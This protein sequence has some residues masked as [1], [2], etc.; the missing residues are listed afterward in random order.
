M[1]KKVC[2]KDGSAYIGNNEHPVESAAK[3]DVESERARAESL[4]RSV[5]DGLESEGV[6]LLTLGA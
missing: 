1:A 2:P 4:D 6:W 5:V 3:A